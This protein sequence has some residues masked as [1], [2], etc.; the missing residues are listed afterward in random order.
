MSQGR[1]AIWHSH[2]RVPL[3]GFGENCNLNPFAE[4][5]EVRDNSYQALGIGARPKLSNPLSNEGNFREIPTKSV[6]FE[7]VEHG[8]R[9]TFDNDLHMQDVFGVVDTPLQGQES[10]G[11]EWGPIMP[12]AIQTSTPKVVDNPIGN[13]NTGKVDEFHKLPDRLPSVGNVTQ[14][15]SRQRKQKDPQTYD[16][17]TDFNDYIIHFEQVSNWNHWGNYEK[18]QQLA[19]SLRG[20]A[21]KILA[22]LTMSQLGNYAQIKDILAERFAPP[23]RENAYRCQLKNRSYKEKESINSYGL[24][25]R[26]LAALSFPDMSPKAREVNIIDQ[27]IHGLRSHEMKKHVQFKHP[28]TLEAAITLAIEFESFENEQALTIKKPKAYVDS[29]EQAPVLGVK[30]EANNM[31]D[32]AQLLLDGLK[33]IKEEF[34]KANRGRNSS[35][36]NRQGRGRGND[37]NRGN[38]PMNGTCFNCGESGHYARECPNPRRIENRQEATEQKN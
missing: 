25:L 30:H 32:L 5:F 21:Q 36:F 12:S 27:F 17:S 22:D 13:G 7:A 4:T 6:N 24:E 31:Q 29:I 18:A 20:A 23:G 10:V 3:Q 16:G 14:P 11:F 26:R 15:F 8:N 9:G 1:G 35:G 37:R 34:Q 19:M 33:D 28:T 2:R 38:R